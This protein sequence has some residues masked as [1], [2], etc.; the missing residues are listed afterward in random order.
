MTE[1]KRCPHCNRHVHL[2]VESNRRSYKVKCDSWEYHCGEIVG[3]GATS[4]DAITD[5][6]A[7][8]YKV[9]REMDKKNL[10][11]WERVW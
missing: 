10:P 6:N 9:I 4:E 1:A 5:W 8:V 11:E 3:Y 2:Y 7:K